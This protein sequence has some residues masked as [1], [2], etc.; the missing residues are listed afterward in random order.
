M[1]L[2][3]RSIALRSMARSCRCARPMATYTALRPAHALNAIGCLTGV[4]YI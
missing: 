1:G 4:P 3:H 2:G